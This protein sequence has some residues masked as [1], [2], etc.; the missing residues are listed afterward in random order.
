MTMIPVKMWND[1]CT[2]PRKGKRP[3]GRVEGRREDV[4]HQAYQLW[5][6]I[7]SGIPSDAVD[8]AKGMHQE[9]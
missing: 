3:G 5:K 1:V 9:Q 2:I 7:N 6:I 4:R 8:P